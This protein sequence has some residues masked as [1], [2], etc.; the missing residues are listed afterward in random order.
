MNF[1]FAAAFLF[2]LILVPIIMLLRRSE[3][4]NSEIARVYNTESAHHLSFVARG[5]SICVFI[6]ALTVVGARPYVAYDVGGSYLFLTD[7]SRSMQARYSCAEPTFLGRAKRIM[8]ETLDA[9][10]EARSGIIAFDRFAFPITSMTGDR[11]YLGEVIDKGL[12]IGLTYEAT[13]TDLANALTVVAQKKQRL[14]D[15]FGQVE[16]VVLLSDGHIDGDYQRRLEKPIQGLRNESISVLAVGIGNANETPVTGTEA[17]RCSNQHIEIE[18][19]KV[20]IPLRSDVLKHIASET[21]GQYYSEPEANKLIQNLRTQLH[22]RVDDRA[23]ESQRRDISW[24][25]LGIG[26]LGLFGF[27]YLPRGSR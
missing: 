21:R 5:T 22:R 16:Q 15:I 2:L 14:P 23:G 17:G 13:Q 10:P 11:S 24:M 4:R 7:V 8:R 25:F 12:Y 19:E 3:R 26:T 9:I 27:L 1:E 6:V 18:G 20:M